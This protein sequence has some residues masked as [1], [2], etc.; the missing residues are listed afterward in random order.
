M[1]EV[2]RNRIH[3]YVLCVGAFARAKEI[4]NVDAF[5][6][7]FAH[8]GIEFLIECYDAEHMLSLNN[9]VE[10]LTI[11]CKTNGGQIE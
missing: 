7:L 5:N 6:Y 9:A 4:S 11:V 1:S 10:D 2:N 3:Y 8:K